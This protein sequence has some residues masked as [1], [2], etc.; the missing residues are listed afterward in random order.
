MQGAFALPPLGRPWTGLDP[1]PADGHTCAFEPGRVFLLLHSC[2][3]A[4]CVSRG[5][6]LSGLLS[7]SMRELGLRSVRL[8]AP[9]VGGRARVRTNER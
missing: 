5:L 9:P 8:H 2:A 4:L 6:V 1:R 3:D 7:H